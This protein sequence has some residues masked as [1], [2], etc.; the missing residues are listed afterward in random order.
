[1]LPIH[2]AVGNLKLEGELYDSEGA[3]AVA[4]ALPLTVEFQVW[5][6]E[7]HFDVPVEGGLRG[8]PDARVRVGD[9]G[10]WADGGTLCIFFGPTPTSGA[11]EPVSAVPVTVIG[12]VERAEQLR[13]AKERGEITVSHDG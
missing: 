11:E 5:G 4:E 10:L 3:R 9:L 6:D 7:L 1:M 8:R 2:I 12:R 13:S